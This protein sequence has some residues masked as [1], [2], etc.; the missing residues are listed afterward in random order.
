MGSITN[1][2]ANQNETRD[3]KFA[4]P[5]KKELVKP[6]LFYYLRTESFFHDDLPIHLNQFFQD[7]VVD[8]MNSHPK[9]QAITYRKTKYLINSRYG[10]V[11]RPKLFDVGLTS[12]RYAKVEVLI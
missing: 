11:E 8:I 4:V 9:Q 10:N 1:N 5:E 7:R 12:S 3:I 6:P 2:V